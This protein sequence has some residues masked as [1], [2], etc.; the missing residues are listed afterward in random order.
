[1]GIGVTHERERIDPSTVEV[2]SV[3][4]TAKLALSE[5]LDRRA[6]VVSSDSN[7]DKVWIRLEDATDTA[8][9]RG[10]YHDFSNSNAVRIADY[11]G[12]VSLIGGGSKDY[13]VMEY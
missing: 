2:M 6:V 4:A 9:E 7:L 13:F 8:T 12:P 10:I 5:N 1:M 11:T 3:G